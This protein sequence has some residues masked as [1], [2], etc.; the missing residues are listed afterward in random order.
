[1]G[2]SAGKVD[3]K[4]PH[5]LLNVVGRTANK[6]RR[7]ARGSMESDIMNLGPMPGHPEGVVKTAST[8]SG[9]HACAAGRNTRKVD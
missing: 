1:M 2:E 5:V 4:S 3:A 6:S 7:P 8:R 9:F